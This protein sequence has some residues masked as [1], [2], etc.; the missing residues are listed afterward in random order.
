MKIVLIPYLSFIL[1]F[2]TCYQS[3]Q[4]PMTIDKNKIIAEVKSAEDALTSALRSGQLL[5]GVGMH[6]DDSEYRNIWNGEVKTF[7][8]LKTRINKGIE[9]GL[10]SIDYQVKSRD[11]KL[12]NAENVIE[13]L[14]AIEVTTL[15]AKSVTSG[16]TAIT[17]LWQK[18]NGE[19]KLG[20]LHASEL[21]KE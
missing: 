7:D 19:W 6:S 15:K 13:T 12:I 2:D 1:I 5:K 18:I 11:F 9:N 17:I 10:L 21:A 14:D 3:K 4:I 16:Q 20:Y 8:I